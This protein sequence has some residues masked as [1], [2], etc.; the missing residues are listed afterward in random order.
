MQMFKRRK[1]LKFTENEMSKEEVI[2]LTNFSPE[3]LKCINVPREANSFIEGEYLGRNMGEGLK[4]YKNS[5]AGWGLPRHNEIL[6]TLLVSPK[7]DFARWL[8]LWD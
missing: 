7:E 8:K 1:K 2:K 6:K 5:L 4:K 3:F